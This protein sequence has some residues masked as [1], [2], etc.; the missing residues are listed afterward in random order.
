[1]AGE[2]DAV[3]RSPLLESV[4]LAL[5]VRHYSERTVVSYV[6]WVRQYVVFHGRRHPRELGAGGVVRFLEHLAVKGSV[7]ASTQ[8]QALAALLFLYGVVLGVEVGALGMVA[9]AKRPE[10][11]PVVLSREEVGSVLARLQ[12][13]WWLMGSLLY[14]SGMRLSEC[15]R[16]RVRD[17]DFAGPRLLVRRG[18]GQKDRAV[19]LPTGLIAPLQSHLAEVRALHAADLA[20]GLGMV[21]LPGALTVKYP[22]AA[23]EWP[24][25]WVFPASRHHV[26]KRTGARR[27]HHVHETALQRAMRA[28]VL[29]AGLN[30]AASCHTLRHS[31]ATHLLEAGYDVRTIQHLLGHHDLR[32]TMVY[33]HVLQRGPFGVQSPLDRLGSVMAS[34]GSSLAFGAAAAGSLYINPEDEDAPLSE[35]LPPSE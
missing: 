18:K 31:F 25:Q 15:V 32:T 19:L 3:G 16:L 7:S 10:K 13:V 21:A 24:W 34:G 30:K 22:K 11:V 4:R 8:N 1:M 28:A 17:V 33:T 35:D 29:A 6:R 23:G 20:R 2:V 12:G 26:E 5:R 27:R 14:G 9:R